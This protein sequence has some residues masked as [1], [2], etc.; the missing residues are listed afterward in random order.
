MNDFTA[1]AHINSWLECLF[2][3]T[4]FI[5]ALIAIFKMLRAPAAHPA[6]ESL[7]LSSDELSRRVAHLEN[8]NTKVWVK[9]ETDARK[10]EKQIADVDKN[11]GALS[12]TIEAINNNCNLMKLSLDNLLRRK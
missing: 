4:A 5:T 3:F 12:A 10:I 9:M 6:N 8:E 2:W 11:V 1:P 7:A